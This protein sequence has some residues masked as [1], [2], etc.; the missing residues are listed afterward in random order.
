VFRNGPG[1]DQLREHDFAILC[2]PATW[3]WK[4]RVMIYPRSIGLAL[5]SFAIAA[6]AFADTASGEACSKTLPPPAL[7][8]YRA[9]SPDMKTNTDMAVL[10]RQKTIPLVMSGDMTRTTARPA[11]I[12]A[13][14]C[15]EQ[16]RK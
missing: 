3:F 6:P 14:S 16:L 15:L 2:G 11:A 9:A 7:L 12:A 8:I 5:A 10:L 1:S 13:S 4:G